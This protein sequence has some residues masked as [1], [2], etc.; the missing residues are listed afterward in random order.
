M[1]FSFRVVKNQ[2]NKDRKKIVVW[3]LLLC[4]L[5]F[6]LVT[7]ADTKGDDVSKKS[8][9][10]FHFI[11]FSFFE[12]L[13]C[14]R[15]EQRFLS[16]PLGLT[17]VV[18][19]LYDFMVLAYLCSLLLNTKYNDDSFMIF[20]LKIFTIFFLHF[21]YELNVNEAKPNTADL[22]NGKF[23]ED[24]RSAWWWFTIYTLFIRNFHGK[25]SKVIHFTRT[26]A[27][28]PLLSTFFLLKISFNSTKDLS[29]HSE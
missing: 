17:E 22:M 27:P 19:I 25:L 29:K 3:F 5:R 24:D 15:Q 21:S 7:C 10:R 9:F 28:V 20:P 12:S 4:S 16:V 14:R 1:V 6:C 26:M 8:S 11:F 23:K 2:E 13:C 18:F